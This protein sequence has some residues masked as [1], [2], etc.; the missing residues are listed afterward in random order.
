MGTLH[1][2]GA[3]MKATTPQ[4]AGTCV[5]LRFHFQVKLLARSVCV[6]PPRGQRL[7]D[8]A[9]AHSRADTHSQAEGRVSCPLAGCCVGSTLFSGVQA[10]GQ[11]MRVTL[12]SH[13]EVAG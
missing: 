9:G 7:L 4:V 11:E 2:Q 1:M 8:E 13:R 12:A 3:V 10:E 5:I 6:I